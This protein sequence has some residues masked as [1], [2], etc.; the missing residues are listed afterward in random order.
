MSI[1]FDYIFYRVAKFY[2]RRDGRLASTALIS[3]TTTQVMPASAFIIFIQKCL[4]GREI[5]ASYSKLGAYLF[6][7]VLLLAM[8]LNHLRYKDKYF[9]LRERWEHETK[10]QQRIRGVAV[11]IAIVMSWTSLL[12]LGIIK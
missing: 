2:Y 11:V 8:F 9:R 1:I 7:V 12:L 4:Y 3:V 5:T 6:V 10:A